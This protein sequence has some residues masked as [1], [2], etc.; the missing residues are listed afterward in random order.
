MIFL[1]DKHNDDMKDNLVKQ[2]FVFFSGAAPCDY[3]IPH[4]CF[5]AQFF[6]AP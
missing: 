4:V 3:A 6:K 5:F 1:L 2:S